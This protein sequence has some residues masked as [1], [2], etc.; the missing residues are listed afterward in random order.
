MEG[1]ELE[2]IQGRLHYSLLPDSGICGRLMPRFASSEWGGSSGVGEG[3]GLGVGLGLT[4]SMSGTG[5]A[6]T[7]TIGNEAKGADP[8]HALNASQKLQYSTDR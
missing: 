8:M 2:P 5:T 6:I 3:L 1:R 7:H 4:G